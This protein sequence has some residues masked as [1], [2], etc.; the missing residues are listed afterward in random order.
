MKCCR[1]PESGQADPGGAVQLEEPV[2]SPKE[3]MALGQA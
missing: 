1:S 2:P 3:Q